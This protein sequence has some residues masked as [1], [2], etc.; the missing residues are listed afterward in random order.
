MDLVLIRG[1][2]QAGRVSFRMHQ[3]EFRHVEPVEEFD[4]EGGGAPE[5]PD[6]N[7]RDE[8]TTW[9]VGRPNHARA[10]VGLKQ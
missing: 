7:P 9:P 1:R 2:L 3:P 4:S 8:L 5:D 6:G 10:D